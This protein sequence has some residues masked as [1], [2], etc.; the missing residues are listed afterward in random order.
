MIDDKDDKNNKK[1][2]D[3]DEEEK[4]TILTKI[5]MIKKRLASEKG[6]HENRFYIFSSHYIVTTNDT[7][8]SIL[9]FIVR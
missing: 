3:E 2:L 5:A 9:V 1:E 7:E 4:M 8:Y 6:F